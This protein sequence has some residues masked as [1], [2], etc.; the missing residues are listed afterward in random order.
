MTNF[1]Q[2]KRAGDKWYSPPFYSHI[3]GY[4]ICIRVVA[5]GERS[6]VGTHVSVYVHLMR[7][8]YNDNLLWPFRGDITFQLVNH[9]ADEGHVEET[10]HFDYNA[11]D[12]AAGRVTDSERAAGGLGRLNF[13]PH[14]ALCYDDFWNTEYLKNDS[15]EFQVTRIETGEKLSVNAPNLQPSSDVAQLDQ[16]Q[17]QPVPPITFIMSGFISR[18]VQ[19][20]SWFSPLFYSH[21]GG[22][23]LCLMVD[24]YGLG[25][26]A[27]THVTV[28]VCLLRGEY[29]DNLLWSFRGDITFQLVNH[30]AD[31]G[32]VETTLLFDDSAPDAAAGRVTYRKRATNVLGC[33][34]SHSA[35]HFDKSKNTQYLKNDS[36]EF[37]VTRIV[38]FSS[39]APVI[40]PNP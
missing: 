5:N 7:G 16:P 38:V 26:G 8:E 11:P 25:N 31:E 23:K 39:P 12:T 36:L 30:R 13:I 4:K 18:K 20:F 22:Y 33:D 10:L 17:V 35:L 32:H 28:N 3:G 15:L 37:Q 19:G 21:T 6:V 24:A 40:T 2:H 34:L 27:G 9:R 29:D 14:S 1:T